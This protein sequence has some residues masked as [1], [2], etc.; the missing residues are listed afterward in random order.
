MH[1][2][3]II[4]RDIKPDNF[5]MGINK[6]KH[7]VYI[8]D[9]GLSKKY[10]DPKTN[11][12]IPYKDGKS[13]TGTARYASIFTHLGIEQA[14]RDDLESLGYLILY[15]LIGELPWQGIKAKSKKEKYQKIMEKKLYTS[16]EQLCNGQPSKKGYITLDEFVS[17]FQYCRGLQFDEKPDYS[18]LKCLLKSIFERY[19]YDYDYVYDWIV[20]NEKKSRSTNDADFDEDESLPEIAEEGGDK[21][22]WIKIGTVIGGL[23]KN[24]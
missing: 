24:K 21:E 16:L 11:E 17:F 8:V 1:S 4:H 7:L 22:D 13:L 10:K 23:Y 19:N 20:I 6:K 3:S 15:M 2:K 9:F 18:Y 14:R 5:I 12:H